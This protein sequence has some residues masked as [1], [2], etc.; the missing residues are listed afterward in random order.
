MSAALILTAVSIAVAVVAVL[1]GL[2]LVRSLKWESVDDDQLEYRL[3][4]GRSSGRGWFGGLL[5]PRHRLLTYRRDRRGRFRR[6][7]R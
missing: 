5:A 6:Y 2:W 3:S 4:R 7:R 1:T